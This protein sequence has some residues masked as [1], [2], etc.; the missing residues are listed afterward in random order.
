MAQ[1]LKL[2]KVSYEEKPLTPLQKMLLQAPVMNNKQWEKFKKVNK[3]M[4]TW[5]ILP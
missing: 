3:R 5:K 1:I 2:K 4:A